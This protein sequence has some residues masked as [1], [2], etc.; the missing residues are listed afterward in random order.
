MWIFN[1]EC[2]YF[3]SPSM[4]C[5]QR[6][7]YRHLSCICVN[8]SAAHCLFPCL[9]VGFLDDGIRFHCQRQ[10]SKSRS[11]Y[12]RTYTE[13]T[14]IEISIKLS[15]CAYDDTYIL[16]SACNTNLWKIEID[17]FAQHDDIKCQHGLSTESFN[18]WKYISLTWNVCILCT[19]FDWLVPREW[20]K[21][22]A[23]C[24]FI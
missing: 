5:T 2:I 13:P 4:R 7:F 9:P 19:W 1:T 21:K 12:V 20:K 8:F 6:L 3:L 22:H 10:N 11:A 23:M 24:S 17:T 15:R 18:K 16:L 14:A